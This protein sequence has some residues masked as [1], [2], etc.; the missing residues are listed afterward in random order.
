MDEMV[1]RR[2]GPVGVCSV[3]SV[4]GKEEVESPGPPRVLGVDWNHQRC[5][6]ESTAG[7]F[8]KIPS[9]G[10]WEPRNSPTTYGVFLPYGRTATYFE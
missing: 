8:E 9:K 5:R 2:K 3:L 10:H 4:G 7:T 6:V 1:L